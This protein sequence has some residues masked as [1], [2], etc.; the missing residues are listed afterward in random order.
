MVHDWDA[1][2]FSGPATKI[3]SGYIRW[4]EVRLAVMRPTEIAR[5]SKTKCRAEVC[6]EPSPVVLFL[7]DF[8]L[9]ARM[10][11]SHPAFT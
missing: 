9:A 11:P 2:P 5:A 7:G 3:L 8:A 6:S 4:L 1:K 10:R